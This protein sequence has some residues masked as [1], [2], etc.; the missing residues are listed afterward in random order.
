MN[1]SSQTDNTDN[2]GQIG[3]TGERG[4]FDNLKAFCLKEERL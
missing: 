1:Y 3:K 4:Q 2:V